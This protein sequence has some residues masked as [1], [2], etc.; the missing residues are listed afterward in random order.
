MT[1]DATILH[2]PMAPASEM[3]KSLDVISPAVPPHAG[4]SSKRLLEAAEQTAEAVAGGTRNSRALRASAA[5]ASIIRRR[6]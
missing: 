1:Q 4:V 3:K 6:L 5:A 2:A